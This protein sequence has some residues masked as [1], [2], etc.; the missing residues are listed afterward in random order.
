M[1]KRIK[2]CAFFGHRDKDYREQVSFWRAVIQTLAERYGVTQFYA[3]GRG[4]FDAMCAKIVQDCKTVYPHIKITQVLSY[5]PKEKE[6]DTLKSNYDD[7]I[8]LLERNVPKRYA[9]LET[10]KTLVNRVDYVCSGVEYGWGGA[11]VKYW[12]YIAK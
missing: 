2:S 5:I 6:E 12:E 7:S 8:Y 11:Y 10:N 4:K 3:G 1:E 9:I